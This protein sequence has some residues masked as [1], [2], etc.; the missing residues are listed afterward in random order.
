MRITTVL[1]LS[2][3][4]SIFLGH[5]AS[6]DTAEVTSAESSGTGPL[7]D[8]AR[9][10]KEPLPANEPARS[11]R[12][13]TDLTLV[14]VTVT[15]SFGRNVRGLEKQNFRVFENA[16][17]RSIVAFGREDAPV[18]VGLIFDSSRSMTDK[19]KMAR[20]AA[21]Q[22]LGQL[23]ADDEAFLV[24]ASTRAELRQDFTSNAGEIADA[25]VFTNPD[26]STSLLDGVNLG[27]EHLKKSH[28]PRKAL[29]VVSDGGENNSRYTLRELLARAVEAD[30]LIYTICLFQDPQ[31]TEELA[32]PDLL[33]NLARKTGGITFFVKDK[34]MNSLGQVMAT[35]GVTLHNQYVLGY[36]PPENGPASKYRKIK[37]QLLLPKGMPEL[38]IYAGTGYY[39]PER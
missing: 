18:S 21:S 19:F 29:V 31:S 37:V 1:T 17:Q 24:T 36:Y 4:G 25:L 28:T 20:E 30:T 16:E 3:F 13:N 23:T 7:L 35:I 9:R 15:D 14:P 38:H 26:G 34:E 12:V 2:L 27:L 39:A 22:L 33:A 6:L 8:S 5:A 32:G 10:Q 11:I